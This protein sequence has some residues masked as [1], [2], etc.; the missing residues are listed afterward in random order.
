MKEKELSEQEIA[1]EQANLQELV[2]VAFNHG[3]ASAIKTAQKMNNPYILDAFHDLLVD[4]LYDE[5]VKRHR[6]EEL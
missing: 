2:D 4:K 5:L 1:K 3:I 6:L